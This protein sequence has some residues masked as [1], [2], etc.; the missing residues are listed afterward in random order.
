M[1]FCVSCRITWYDLFSKGTLPFFVHFP[2][3]AAGSKKYIYPADYLFSSVLGSIS[4]FEI[5]SLYDWH[6]G[7][8]SIQGM[9]LDFASD[10]FLKDSTAAWYRFRGTPNFTTAVT[11]LKEMYKEYFQHAAENERELILQTK[12]FES[13]IN[14][15]L[16]QI[17][18]VRLE[19]KFKLL[20]AE[21]KWL[22]WR[23][24]PLKTLPSDFCP[25]GLSVLDL[26]KSKNIERLWSCSWWSCIWWSW[27][28]N[29]VCSAYYKYS[30]PH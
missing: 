3:S 13:M 16:L 18:N 8:R 24:C 27:Y 1:E 11:W 9:V 10:I 28:N 23:G 17:D 26:S 21:L 15:R 30:L 4:A 7:S 22:Q 20:P 2:F 12:S 6:Q 25:Q 19:G 29:K 14:L 5:L